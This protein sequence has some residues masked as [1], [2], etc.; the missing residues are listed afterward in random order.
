M[1]LY[2]KQFY[3]RAESVLLIKTADDGTILDYDI[4]DEHESVDMILMMIM[5]MTMISTIIEN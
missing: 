5:T 4:D 1:L 2:L 3:G